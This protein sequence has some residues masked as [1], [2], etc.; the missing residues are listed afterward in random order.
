MSFGQLARVVIEVDLMP[1]SHGIT[2]SDLERGADPG[3]VIGR[4]HRFTI[5][6]MGTAREIISIDP[7]PVVVGLG[8]IKNALAGVPIVIMDLFNIDA[9]EIIFRNTHNMP[10][11]R[12]RVLPGGRRV[13]RPIGP[14]GILDAGRQ[15]PFHGD[16]CDHLASINIARVAGCP[17]PRVQTPT[18]RPRPARQRDAGLHSRVISGRFA[19]TAGNIEEDGRNASALS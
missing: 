12:Q 11:P 9:S 14:V 1:V 16:L 2:C 6:R 3:M 4:R 17:A 18:K 19:V 10:T 5:V 7:G 8:I 15:I 13:K